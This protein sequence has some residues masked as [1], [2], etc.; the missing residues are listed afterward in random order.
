MENQTGTPALLRRIEELAARAADDDQHRPEGPVLAAA[1]TGLRAELGGLRADLGT[2]RADLSA[3]RAGMD[4][5]TGRLGGALEATRSQAEELG[6]RHDELAGKVDALADTMA[7]IKSALPE[8]R[9]AARRPALDHRR[10]PDRRRAG[11][12]TTSRPRSTPSART[13]GARCPPG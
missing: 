8:L 5:G 2:L 1:L 13:C 9:V 11:W 7:E 12:R 10:S 6:N 3:V 4:A